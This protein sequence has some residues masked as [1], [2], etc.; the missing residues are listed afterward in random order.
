MKLKVPMSRSGLIA[1]STAVLIKDI[2]SELRTRYSLNAV[3]MF[4][5]V[6]V[7]AVGFATSGTGLPENMQ[8][9]FFWIVLYFA[10]L[11][12]MG[13]SFIKEEENRTV[14]LLRLHA[15]PTSIFVGKLL[16]NLLILLLLEAVIL[17]LYAVFIGLSVV[18]W[19]VFFETLILATVG[20]AGATTII[21]AI[22][23]KASVKSVLFAVLSFPIMLPLLIMAIKATEK[24][25]LPPAFA[26]S[27]APELRV[28]ISYAVIMIVAGFLLFE[29]IWDE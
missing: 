3:I 23:S 13:Q 26:Q 21:A 11:A 22:V 27:A 20:L 17:P 8:G 4:A 15:D 12:G 5:V 24:S 18:D 14:T 1:K 2:R 7:L 10:S 29:Y 6:T 9:I 28:L 25:M 19:P 16:F